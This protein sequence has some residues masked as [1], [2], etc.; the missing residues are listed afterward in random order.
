MTR[1]HYSIKIQ[2][3]LHKWQISLTLP[4]SN[5]INIQFMCVWA[6][7]AGIKLKKKCRE[8][9][10]RTQVF[11]LP[12]R[13]KVSAMRSQSSE[14]ACCWSSCQCNHRQL[15]QGY[16]HL[17]SHCGDTSLRFGPSHKLSLYMHTHTHTCLCQ[18]LTYT[19]TDTDKSWH[20]QEWLTKRVLLSLYVWTRLLSTLFLV[21]TLKCRW[22]LFIYL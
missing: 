22:F 1:Q 2:Q 4:L 3:V 8:A 20:C 17:S 16:A 14:E 18:V 13:F 11:P 19:R 7:T 15:F 21:L 5:H 6:V 9:T 10:A 12:A